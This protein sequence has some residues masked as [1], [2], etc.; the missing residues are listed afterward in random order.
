M[1]DIPK[2]Q[3]R[4]IL[5]TSDAILGN[6]DEI[7]PKTALDGFALPCCINIYVVFTLIQKYCTHLGTFLPGHT[8]QSLGPHYTLENTFDEQKLNEKCCFKEFFKLK[9]RQ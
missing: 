8:R 5:H 1:M 4:E 3:Y 2:S 6:S 9:L 7:P